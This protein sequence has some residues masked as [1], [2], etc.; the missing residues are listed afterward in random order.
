M[1]EFVVGT[2]GGLLRDFSSSVAANS[3][4]RLAEAFGVLELRFHPDSYEWRFV[5]TDGKTADQGSDRCR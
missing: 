5:T 2:G 4:F 3:E 1:R